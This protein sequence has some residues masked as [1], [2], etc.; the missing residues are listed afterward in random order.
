MWPDSSISWNIPGLI[1]WDIPCLQIHP[2]PN[3][4]LQGRG[5]GKVYYWCFLIVLQNPVASFAFLLGDLRVH[6]AVLRAG[7]GCMGRMAADAGAGCGRGGL[8]AGQERV[9]VIVAAFALTFTAAAAGNGNLL[10]GS[11]AACGHVLVALEAVLIADGMVQY[12]RLDRA[13]GIPQEGI[14]RPQ[15][16]G[17][18]APGDSRPGVAVDAGSFLGGMV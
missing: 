15:Q 12:G 14:V 5:W 10:F 6:E 11:I 16:L 9:P 13:A 3:P 8:P 2:P 17:L 1:F 18:H 7:I 4:R